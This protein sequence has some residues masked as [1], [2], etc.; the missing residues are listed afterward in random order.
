MVA[1]RVRI[2]L[3]LEGYIVSTPQKLRKYKPPQPLRENKENQ[4]ALSRD[5][6]SP[7]LQDFST[8]NALNRRW[9]YRNISQHVCCWYKTYENLFLTLL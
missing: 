3:N 4:K 5:G 6:R 1:F 9:K 7:D 2:N 8:S